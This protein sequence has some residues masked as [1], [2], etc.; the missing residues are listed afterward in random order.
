M[1]ADVSRRGA[2]AGAATLGAAA[3]VA[4]VAGQA[5]AQ[6][7]PAPTGTQL[8]EWRNPGL[9]AHTRQAG[10]LLN[11]ERAYRIMDKHGLDGLVASVPHNIYYLS[12]HTGPMQMMGRGFSTY[13]FFPRRPDAPP[14]LI[15][16]GSMLYHLDYRPTWMPVEVYTYPKAGGRGE[17]DPIPSPWAHNL[18]RGDIRDRDR[19]LMALYA[20]YEGLT[21]VSALAGLAKALRAAGAANGTI[22]FD[23]PRV[24]GWLKQDGLGLR[25]V[26]AA[27]IFREIRMVKTPAEVAIL[28]EAARKNEDALLYA[29]H[30]TSVGEPLDNIEANH[31]KKW[32]ELGGS[33]LWCITN[34]RGI[35]SGNVERDTITK[36]DSVGQYKMYRGDV[37][38]TVVWGTPTDEMARRIEANT[39]ALRITYDAI[40]P[41]MTFAESSK[42]MRD[43]MQQEGF[44][45]GGGGAHPV[46]LEHTDHPWP[47]GAEK[48]PGQLYGALVYEENMVFTMDVPFHE[49]GWGTSHVEDMMVVKKS[50]GCEG[51]SS[52]DTRLIVRPA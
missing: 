10:K 44:E 33:T 24:G 14:A 6:A 30:N 8:G 39:K 4:A 48:D 52:M 13:A 18:R 17:A 34:Q 3:G 7:A 32:G 41:G 27:N 43:V 25:T 46:G 42:I 5:A 47:T 20:E 49:P 9:I 38:R 21:S 11:V 22:G 29:I 31:G 45:R 37:G 2:L 36:I 26:D 35:A 28:R 50:G 40:R 15:V 51:L 23:D 12:S 16:P 19:V 1:T